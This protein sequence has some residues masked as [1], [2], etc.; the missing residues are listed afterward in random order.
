MLPTRRR[1]VYVVKGKSMEV[2]PDMWP[3]DEVWADDLTL[4]GTINMKGEFQPN[5]SFGTSVN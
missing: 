4:L 3:G 2:Q 5:P 1:R